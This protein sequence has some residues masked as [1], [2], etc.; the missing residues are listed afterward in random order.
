M[1]SDE[2]I[3]L[4][5]LFSL[6]T[7][8]DHHIIDAPTYFHYEAEIA[9]IAIF[10]FRSTVVHSRENRFISYLMAIFLACLAYLKKPYSVILAAET[11]SYAV[12]WLLLYKPKW[13]QKKNVLIKLLAL[14]ASAALS[15]F[16]SNLVLESMSLP[17][18]PA[19]EANDGIFMNMINAWFPVDELRAAYS[20]MLAFAH[21]NVLQ[22]QLAHLFFVTFHIQVGMGF[23]GIGFLLE[24]QSRRNMLIRLDV[25]PSTNSDGL[26]IK[27]SQ[28]ESGSPDGKVDTAKMA[29][30]RRYQKGAGPFILFIALPYMFQIIVY[31]NINRFAFTCLEQDL[32]RT[33]RLND[34]FDNDSNLAAMAQADNAVSPESKQASTFVIG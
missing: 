8:R 9:A 1:K 34:L 5:G 18:V 19:K 13:L 26:I 17:D 4:F 3:L 20:I 33:V 25:E 31:G 6:S 15:W 11:F 12:S 21:P 30:A 16:L 10:F 29:R 7:H 24:E 27:E 23:L 32:H 22:S 2:E 28:S 14:A